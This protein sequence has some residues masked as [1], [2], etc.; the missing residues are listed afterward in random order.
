MCANQFAGALLCLLPWVWV[1]VA[2][3]QLCRSGEPAAG[4]PSISPD[5][6][7][8]PHI[9]PHYPEPTRAGFCAV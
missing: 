4:F 2:W 3:S 5:F 7:G 6:Q 1:L 8:L 9:Q